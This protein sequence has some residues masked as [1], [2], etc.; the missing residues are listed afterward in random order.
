MLFGT[1]YFSP[2]VVIIKVVHFNL[3][4][5]KMKHVSLK[6]WLLHVLQVTPA[7]T[8]RNTELFSAPQMCVLYDS[9]NN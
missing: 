1:F 4:F 7:A 3:L 9:H 6:V 8:L 5:M 2:V